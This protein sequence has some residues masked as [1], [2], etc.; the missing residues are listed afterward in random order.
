MASPGRSP[1]G[2]DIRPPGKVRWILVSVLSRSAHSP[3]ILAGFQDESGHSGEKGALP[4]DSPARRAVG[5]AR[6]ASLSPSLSF[7]PRIEFRGPRSRRFPIRISKPRIRDRRRSPPIFLPF[8]HPY[9]PIFVPFDPSI[10][11]DTV[12]FFRDNINMMGIMKGRWTWGHARRGRGVN[13]ARP[14]RPAV[15]LRALFD[16]FRG[17][18]GRARPSS[19]L[20]GAFCRKAVVRRS[21]GSGPGFF[22]TVEFCHFLSLRLFLRSGPF[23]CRSRV[24]E[25]R[26]PVRV[27]GAP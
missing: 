6:A 11:L 25:A 13:E 9:P 8:S 22:Q 23:P 19:R 5:S 1:R 27:P 18:S 3:A 4:A 26:G 15:R 12:V 14:V 16:F 10:R 20:S 7:G 2:A 17:L 21:P 24:R